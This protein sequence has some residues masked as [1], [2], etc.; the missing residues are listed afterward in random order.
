MG[1]RGGGRRMH[2]RR[3][4][5]FCIDKV[6]LID[7]KDVQAVAELPSRTRQDFAATNLR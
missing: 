1:G 6:D 4:V 2:R 5:R 7:F 3:V